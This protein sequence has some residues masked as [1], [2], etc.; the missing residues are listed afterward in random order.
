MRTDDLIESLAREVEPAARKRPAAVIGRAGGVGLALA[1]ALMLMLLGPRPDIGA[2]LPMV[3][4]KAA[5]SAALGALAIP[6][7]LTLARPGGVLGR[8]LAVLLAG[9]G[10][11]V[12]IGLVSLF[13][14]APGERIAALTGG[15]MPWC[16]VLIPVLASP[17][18]GALV[19]AMRD[20]AP[21]RLAV[22]GA[23]IGGVAGGVGAMV[24]ALYCPVDRLAFVTV[25]YACAIAICAA[26]GAVFATRLLRW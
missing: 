15:A 12:A 21:T 11:S 3:F 14:A 17:V 6:A 4:A 22:T 10:L 18:A 26:L 7:V 20:M 24:Y 8:R 1:L 25:W 2:A 5:F 13:G 23:A 16:L 19:Y 9:L